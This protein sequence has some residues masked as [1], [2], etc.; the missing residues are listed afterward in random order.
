MTKKPATQQGHLYIVSA[1]RHMDRREMAGP[2]PH[3]HRRGSFQTSVEGVWPMRVWLQSSRPAPGVTLGTTSRAT[4]HTHLSLTPL[5]DPPSP[6]IEQPSKSN[7]VSRGIR[8]SR[9]APH[10]HTPYFLAR[11]MLGTVHLRVFCRGSCSLSLSKSILS[12]IPLFSSCHD[13]SVALM[14]AIPS[15]ER[16]DWNAT[17]LSAACS[18]KMLPAVTL[19]SVSS[20]LALRVTH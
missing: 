18:G 2:T 12:T 7:Q 14:C 20:Y 17:S 3:P 10:H 13:A 16:H 9:T 1:T 8:G 6:V 5:R 19:L 11:L 15:C 4:T